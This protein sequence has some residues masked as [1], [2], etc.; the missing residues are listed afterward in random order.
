MSAIVAVGLLLG[1]LVYGLIAK[2][3]GVSL[4]QGIA[5][6]SPRIAPAMRLPVLAPPEPGPAPP[7]LR[8]AIAD[9]SVDLRE[10]QGVPVVINFWASWCEPCRAEA[11]VLEQGWRQSRADG[12]AFV[13]LNMQDLTDDAQAFIDEFGLSYLNVR[14]KSDEVATRWGLTGLPETYFVD[15]AGRVV[16]HVIGAVS[17]DQLRTGIEAARAGEAVSAGSGGDRRSIR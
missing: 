17:A 2:A 9:G 11:G 13:G 3:P 5:D 4:D 6:S 15:R 7:K 1:L 8:R 12:V 10:L 16:A 14:D